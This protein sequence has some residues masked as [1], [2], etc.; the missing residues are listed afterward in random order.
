MLNFKHFFFPFWTPP[1]GTFGTFR[2]G[3]RN[4]AEM[5][6]QICKFEFIMTRTSRGTYLAT[7]LALVSRQIS[8]KYEPSLREVATSPF[9]MTMSTIPSWM[10]YIFVPIVP[11]LVDWNIF[12]SCYYNGGGEK[13]SEKYLFYKFF[14]QPFSPSCNE[15]ENFEMIVW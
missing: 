10:K 5:E 7:L 6:G 9:C 1:L 8:P 13:E 11:S 14:F 12:M 2:I 4:D 15:W 3:G